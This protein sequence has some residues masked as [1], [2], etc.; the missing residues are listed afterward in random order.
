MNRVGRLRWARRNAPLTGFD[1]F[2]DVEEAPS[3]P[4]ALFERVAGGTAGSYPAHL[5]LRL[6]KLPPRLSRLDRVYIAQVPT[7][8]GYSLAWFVDVP[9]R[10][11]MTLA[12]AL[13]GALIPRRDLPSS[14]YALHQA[15]LYLHDPEA[16]EFVRFD[17]VA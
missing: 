2:E 15:P 4:V 9:E 12:R 8:Q 1:L 14:E 10:A 13:R 16:G 11:T 5:Y 6:Q 3:S 7:G 17:V